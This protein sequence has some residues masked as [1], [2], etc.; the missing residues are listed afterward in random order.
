MAPDLIHGENG[1]RRMESGMVVIDRHLYI[2]EDKSR[3]VEE[4]DPAGRW[5]WASP[6]QEMPRAQAERLGALKAATS[7]PAA[8]PE[9][10]EAETGPEPAEVPEPQAKARRKP[11]DKARKPDGDK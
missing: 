2:T 10:A 4:G 7:E 11:A 8:E 6:G 9:G 5:L 3:V 1:A